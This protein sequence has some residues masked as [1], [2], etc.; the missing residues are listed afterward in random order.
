MSNDQKKKKKKNQIEI[1]EA[2]KSKD[3]TPTE[4]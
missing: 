3:N 2:L 1:K 4:G